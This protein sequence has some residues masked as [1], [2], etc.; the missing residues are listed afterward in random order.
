MAHQYKIGDR[1]R[2]IEREGTADKY[3]LSYVNKMNN[4]FAGRIVTIDNIVK[5]EASYYKACLMY[6]GD[7]N[8]YRIKE[9]NYK[10]SWHSSMFEP[11][12]NEEV[13][14]P[15]SFQVGQKVLF[16]DFIGIVHKS[17]DN[18]YWLD[19]TPSKSGT[20]SESCRTLETLL[21]NYREIG[22][23]FGAIYWTEESCC[24]PIFSSLG[25]LYLYYCELVELLNKPKTT[26][27]HDE[28]RFQKEGSSI[29]RGAVPTGHSISG[30]RY[31]ATVISG[32]LSYKAC[33][34]R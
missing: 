1:V 8:G 21:P 33:F 20:H 9:D 24:I 2:I 18:L 16:G 5:N 4:E 22:K 15:S 27:D 6:N 17:S 32:H 30:R 13:L 34:G 31:Q 25:R 12:Q 19:L 10:Y 28:I 26:K 11:V 29:E 3:P 7:D 23:K 14:P